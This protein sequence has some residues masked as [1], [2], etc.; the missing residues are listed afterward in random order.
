MNKKVGLSTKLKLLDFLHEEF[1]VRKATV[2]NLLRNNQN[3]KERIILTSNSGISDENVG[4]LIDCERSI[5]R[6][7]RD[8]KNLGKDIEIIKNWRLEIS[9]S[10]M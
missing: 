10:E 5:R 4:I 1:E 8:L 7:T 3:E 2:K 6:F 9:E